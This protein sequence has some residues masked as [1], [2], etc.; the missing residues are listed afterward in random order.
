[1]STSQDRRWLALALLA[2]AQFVVVLDASIVNVALPSIGR[3]L[4]FSR[5]D[6]SWV[7][8]A[9]TLTFGGFLLLGGRMADLLGRRRLFIGGLILFAA[10]SLAG[11]LAQSDTWLIAARAVQGLGAALLS[12]AALALVTTLFQ[13]G[14]ERNKAMGVWGAVAGSG[15]AAGVLLGGMLTQW[16]GW[17][18]VLFVN[19]PIGIAAALLAPRLLP[20]SRLDPTHPARHFDVAGAVTVT[21]GLSLFVY[22]LVNANKVGWG[23]VET[24]A[25]VAAA[26]ALIAGFVAIELRTRAPLVPF[27]GVFRLRSIRGINITA[28][29]IAMA[30]FSMFF[31]ISLYMQQV[32]GYDPL[33]AGVSYLPLAGGIIV[34]A[35]M[36]SQLVTRYGVKPV[37][38]SGLLLTAGGLVWFAQIS[39]GGSYLSDI[40]GPSLLSAFGLGLAFVSMTVAAV[41]GVEAHE[42]GLASGLINTSQQVG[43][44]LGLAILA[45][46]SDSRRDSVLASVH[47]LP[48]A[49][50]DGFRTALTVGA[51]FAVVGALLALA[52]VSG[53]GLEQGSDEMEAVPAAASA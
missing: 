29:L 9:Y 30:L 43:G 7:V 8:N 52:L 5:D 47:S 4:H 17:E 15:G 50:T 32:L 33:K 28:L 39:V 48:V 11:G 21:A 18:W 24:I 6:L 45:A 12:P 19:V 22:S 44:A 16:A 40:L 14:A 20:E 37:L 46:V 27:P 53:S 42:S 38:V 35:G 25:L 49:L 2:A 26:V 41:A 13:E 51:G 1:L 31:F 3:A 34:A 36:A 10:A 23:S